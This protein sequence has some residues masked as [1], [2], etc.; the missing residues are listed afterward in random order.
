VEPCE[1]CQMITIIKACRK[2]GCL[3]TK[4]PW[5]NFAFYFR[6]SHYAFRISLSPDQIRCAHCVRAVVGQCIKS[7]ATGASP[8]A[9]QLYESHMYHYSLCRG[10][11]GMVTQVMA[12]AWQSWQSWQ[13]HTTMS[14]ALHAAAQESAAV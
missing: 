7:Q 2:R 9:D 13:R 1:C 8:I 5:N 11:Q 6:I 14:K 4:T 12:E 10:C 3:A